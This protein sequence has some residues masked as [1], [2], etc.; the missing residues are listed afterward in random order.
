MIAQSKYIRLE[1]NPLEDWTFCL[2]MFGLNSHKAPHRSVW[3]IQR[4]HSFLNPHRPV[5]VGV[6]GARYVLQ[7]RMCGFPTWWP[8]FSFAAPPQVHQK[9]TSQPGEFNR[10]EG[11]ESSLPSRGLETCRRSLSA[12]HALSSVRH[13]LT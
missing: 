1:W 3:C 8:M 13:N 4:T 5:P 12:K 10:T 9:R 6:Y 7:Y 2:L 11:A